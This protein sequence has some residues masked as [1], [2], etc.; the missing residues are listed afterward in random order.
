MPRLNPVVKSVIV[1][2]G[3]DSRGLRMSERPVAID[4]FAGAGGLSLGFEQAGFDVVAS[5]EYDPVHAAVH[6]YNFPLTQ[7]ICA[8]ISRLSGDRLREAAVRGHEAHGAGTSWDGEVDVVF[9]GPPCQGFSNIG[10]RL[11]D[12]PRNQLVFHFVRLIGQLRPRYFLMENV[13]GMRAGGHAGILDQLISEFDEAGYK[14]T[15]PYRVLNASDYGVPQ[16]R[17]RLFLLGARN[18]QRDVEY[19]FPTVRA[20]SK[21][22]GEAFR[23]KD[24][25]DGLNLPLGPTVHDALGDL[26]DAD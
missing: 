10:K 4:L 9:G 22:I 17:R 16:D 2:K 21:R 23:P 19:P 12:D 20:V 15:V 25:A 18:D 24:G 5:V 11:V 1:E 3:S 26:L 14:V 6:A 13:P 7:T 8:D